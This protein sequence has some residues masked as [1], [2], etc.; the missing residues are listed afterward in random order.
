MGDLARYLNGEIYSY[1][2]LTNSDRMQQ[3]YYEL[4]NCLI[5]EIT[6]ES[7][8][9]IRMSPGWKIQKFYGNY[10]V[11]TSDL[12][13]FMTDSNKSLVYELEL[14]LVSNS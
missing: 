8:F 9:R 5:K 10:S 1:Q 3:F 14:D 4:K 6:W 11:K 13:S 2:E 12:L 7:V